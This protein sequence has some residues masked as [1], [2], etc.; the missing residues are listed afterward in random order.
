M[1]YT[2]SMALLSISCILTF[3]TRIAQASNKGP[4]AE[5]E[6]EAV[7]GHYMQAAEQCGMSA[8]THQACICFKMSGSA[9]KMNALLATKNP[10][11][12]KPIRY[13][14]VTRNSSGNL[15]TRRGELKYEAAKAIQ[16]QLAACNS[17]S[18][19]A[20]VAN[21]TVTA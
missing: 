1:K 21:Q 19:S 3:E 13:N 9:Q 12:T 4:D 17:A 10:N 5:Q 6:L 18:Q 8:G 15:T 16:Q 7:F 14:Y 11:R 2:I 20:T